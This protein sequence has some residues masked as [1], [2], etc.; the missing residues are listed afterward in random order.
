MVGAVKIS[1]LEGLDLWT[2]SDVDL[3]LG[4]SFGAL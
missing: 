1:L 2:K 3:G 4:S